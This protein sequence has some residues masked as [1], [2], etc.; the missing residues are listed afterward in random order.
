MRQHINISAFSSKRC[1]CS[2]PVIMELSVCLATPHHI[3]MLRARQNGYHFVDDAFKCIFLH[4]NVMISIEISLKFVPKVQINNIPALV[5]IMAWHQQGYSNLRGT[6]EVWKP[7][8][9]KRHISKE[10]TILQCIVTL[11]MWFVQAQLKIQ[12]P[13]KVLHVIWTREVDHSFTYFF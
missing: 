6:N 5:Q 12:I 3:N 9:L 7:V 11:G 4:E 8:F 2:N 1:L 13:W 10:T